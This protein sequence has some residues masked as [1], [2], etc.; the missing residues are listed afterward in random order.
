M[1][2]KDIER[3]SSKHRMTKMV[4]AAIGLSA[5]V[6]C[7]VLYREQLA[8]WWETIQTGQAGNAAIVAAWLLLPVI[9]FP[10]LPLL[11]LTGVRFGSL[12]GVVLMFAGIPLHLVIAFWLTNGILKHRI[13]SLAQNRF[14]NMPRISDER[15][16]RYSAVFMAVPGLSYSLKNYLL[17]LTG[18]PFRI[19]FF[20]AWSIQGLM[21][22]PLVILGDAAS[23]WRFHI[24]AAMIVLF[25]FV[26]LIQKKIW[27]K[28]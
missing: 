7:L 16:I 28:D 17:P 8:A 12:W 14:F 5:L 24:V 3:K 23:K 27:K 9:G 10:V 4:L 18:L 19:Y 26:Y 13:K 20:C 15:Q 6:I 22:V 2:L 25:G 21:G 1:N 11:I